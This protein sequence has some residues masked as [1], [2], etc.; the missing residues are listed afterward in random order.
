[1]SMAESD[2]EFAQRLWNEMP[3]GYQEMPGCTARVKLNLP[4]R[5]YVRVLKMA[6]ESDERESE[7]ARLRDRIAELEAALKLCADSLAEYVPPRNNA[8]SST[9]DYL[10]YQ[11]ARAALQG[12]ATPEGPTHRCMVCGW[13]G[14]AE[15]AGRH[16]DES[17]ENAIVITPEAMRGLATVLGVNV[18]HPTMGG[19]PRTPSFAIEFLF[20]FWR[21][22]MISEERRMVFGAVREAGQPLYN[23]IDDGPLKWIVGDLL[24][25]NCR[26]AV[27][28]PGTIGEETL[29]KV[30]FTDNQLKW[31]P[32]V[33][34]LISDAKR[35]GELEDALRKILEG[36][37]CWGW[38]FNPDELEKIAS[39]A[40][41][42]P[43]AP[44]GGEE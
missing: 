29:R 9:R 7:N 15:D 1:M 38:D 18:W 10:A 23:S 31:I 34:Q 40:L 12:K 19:A 26:W 33:Q 16:A 41:G 4:R 43:A 39:D 22:S 42:E 28:H 25:G 36:S 6:M 20:Q 14:S 30:G 32:Q 44:G 2:R 35:A 27:D 37:R 13:K 24:E 21:E 8:T 3:L 17:D 11:K 5:D